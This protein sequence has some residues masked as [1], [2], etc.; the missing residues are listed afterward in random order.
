M[1][2]EWSFYGPLWPEQS[3]YPAAKCHT[4][5]AITLDHLLHFTEL[6]L[7]PHPVWIPD[8]N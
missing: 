5:S 7:N 3:D 4:P 2:I 8:V 6:E 1:V